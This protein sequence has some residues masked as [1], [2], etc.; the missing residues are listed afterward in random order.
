MGLTE[1]FKVF[2][3]A[4]E[5]DKLSE[6][7]TTVGEIAKKLNNEYYGLTGDDAS[8]M[9]I[10]GS[11]GRGTC[12]KGISDLDILFDLPD[13][14]FKRFDSYKTLKQTSLLQ[15]I[16]RVLKERYPKTDISGDGQV[17]VIEFDKYTVELVP[18]FKQSDNRFKYPDTNDGGS[19][20]YTD[21]LPEMEESH[22]MMTK[23]NQNFKHI[24]NMMRAW[25]NKQGFKFGGLLID[26]LTYKFLN[27]HTQYW[28][29][30]FD[31]YFDMTLELFNFLKDLNQEQSYWF[32][33]GSN[34][35]V[36]NCENGKFVTKAQEAYD[37]L[38]E[39]TESSSSINNKLRNVFGSK[40]PKKLTEE[41]RNFG[42]SDVKQTEQFIEDLYPIDIKY[43]ISI[44]CTVIQNG[45]QTRRLKQML[46]E[47]LPLLPQKKLEF[48]IDEMDSELKEN[49]SSFDIY[50]KVKNEGEVAYQR[51][52]LRGQIERTNSYKQIEHS[53]F[54]G[55]H[56]VEC[57]IIQNG[58]CVARSRIIVPISQSIY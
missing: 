44:D 32:A 47:K 21:P 54:K 55:K 11:V 23:T 40:F 9:Y 24:A 50:W 43:S 49:P 2:I 26:T 37:I 27:E 6:M 14:V 18:G 25:K 53:T 17:V 13:E 5:P 33:L 45:F 10:V 34:Q 36:Y 57:Y 15:E 16:R 7:E 31:Q 35:K 42:Y 28:Y 4:L 38:K 52:C 1:D 51:N 46:R 48:Y 12:I 41:N 8:H 30:G 58:V 56:F 3:E 19:W 22:S 20:K 39:L 29:I